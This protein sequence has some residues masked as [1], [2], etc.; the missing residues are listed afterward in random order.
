MLSGSVGGCVRV[1]GW[2]VHV[3]CISARVNDMCDSEGEGGR[4][5]GERGDDRETVGLFTHLWLISDF[6]GRILRFLQ[7]V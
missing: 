1:G 2:R 4:R 6:V 5:R 3:Y 7:E